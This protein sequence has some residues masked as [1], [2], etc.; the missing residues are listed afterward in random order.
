MIRNRH[1]EDTNIKLRGDLEKCKSHLACVTR[2]NE[3]LTNSIEEFE[4]VDE[5]V[6]KIIKKNQLKKL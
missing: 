2:N 4:Y 6:T 1:I 5:R 3:V